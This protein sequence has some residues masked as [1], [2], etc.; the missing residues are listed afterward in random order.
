MLNNIY[1]KDLSTISP[2]GEIFQLKYALTASNRGNMILGITTLFHTFFVS[3][4]DD[5]KKNKDYNDKILSIAENFG[6][7]VSGVIGDAKYIHKY[8]EKNKTEYEEAFNRPYSLSSAIFDIHKIYSQTIF[9]SKTRPFGVNLILGGYDSTGPNLFS[10]IP[11]AKIE[12]KD[13]IFFGSSKK[14]E[15][16]SLKKNLEGFRGKI[17][18]FSIDETTDFLL[19]DLK[20]NFTN[21]N[22]SIFIKNN[23]RI[24]LVGKKIPWLILEEGFFRRFVEFGKKCIHRP[25]QRKNLINI[26]KKSLSLIFYPPKNR[27]REK[28]FKVAFFLKFQIFF[29]EKK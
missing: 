11:D 12:K 10:F 28:E 13:S 19:R 25:F 15:M 5:V 4:C 16:L 20:K 9:N 22:Y 27:R 26:F 23:L 7:L 2:D 21:E 29:N 17:T 1:D 6:V 24:S 3:C 8:L 18:K 14:I